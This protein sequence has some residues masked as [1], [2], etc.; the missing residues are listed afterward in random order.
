MSGWSARSQDAP[1]LQVAIT[2]T[3][4]AVQVEAD[5]N[6]S[7]SA[8][9][10]ENAHARA[11]SPIRTHVHTSTAAGAEC[12]AS[13]AWRTLAL[14]A[15]DLYEPSH[16][17][18][19][20]DRR[21]P[22]SVVAAES[23]SRRVG[24]LIVPPDEAWLNTVQTACKAG[25]NEARRQVILRERLINL[26]RLV[27]ANLAL[28]AEDDEWVSGQ[29]TRVTALLE[30]PLDEG[31][32]SDAEDSLQR[33]IRR[34]TELKADLDQARIAVKQMLSSLVAHLGAAATHT[35]DLHRRIGERAEAI[36]RADNLA[37]ITQ[38]VAN[39]LADAAEMREHIERT[40]GE[41]NSARKIADESSQRITALEGE[42][43][44]V[45]QLVRVDPLTQ[46]LN[47]RGLDEA[48]HAQKSRAERENLPLAVALLDIDDFKKLNDTLGHQA[49]D[50]ALRHISD[51]MNDTVRPS[52]TVARLGGEEFVI[53]LEATDSAGAATVM[54]RLQRQLTRAIFLHNN[55]KTLITFSVGITSLVP[56]ENWDAVI[57]RAD[58]A[59]Y[60]AKVAGKNCVRVM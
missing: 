37:S 20:S 49:G 15:L 4:A 5:E 13:D 48:F 59:L 31:T 34:Q 53:L 41:L 54:K 28:F 45:S 57:S 7:A 23:L 46:V 36:G 19:P 9:A 2:P 6:A 27:C 39:L 51:L 56:G 60:A 42:L 43:T 55:E 8:N 16:R 17:T 33:A 11:H 58:T 44:E 14:A 47:R 52:D 30:T 10:N 50:L 26:L 40:H 3:T 32:L 38:V 29:V 35:G 12:A 18:D 22:Q 1:S 25:Q 21:E 24:R